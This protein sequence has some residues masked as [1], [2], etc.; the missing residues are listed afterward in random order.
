V[1][2]QYAHI[3]HLAQPKPKTP[4]LLPLSGGKIGVLGF[5]ARYDYAHRYNGEFEKLSKSCKEK[6]R[7]NRH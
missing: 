4:I 3:L 5:G 1:L 6:D 2:N 7:E